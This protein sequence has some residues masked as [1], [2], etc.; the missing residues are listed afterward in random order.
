MSTDRK[1][2]LIYIIC[3]YIHRCMLIVKLL[4]LRKITL[5]T[6]REVTL[7]YIICLYIHICPDIYILI[8]SNLKISGHL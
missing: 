6:D 8:M 4:K 2:T 7:I 1:V 3:L 5:S